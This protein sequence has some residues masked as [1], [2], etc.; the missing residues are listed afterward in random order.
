MDSDKH[1]ERRCLVKGCPEY[2]VWIK[3]P[4]GVEPPA[5]NDPRNHYQ[6]HHYARDSKG[7]KFFADKGET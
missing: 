1:Y 7:R 6:Q 5:T 4:P 2:G 3:L